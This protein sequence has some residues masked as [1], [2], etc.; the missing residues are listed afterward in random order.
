MNDGLFRFYTRLEMNH[1]RTWS[2]HLLACPTQGSTLLHIDGSTTTQRP[3]GISSSSGG[4]AA[5]F[6][7]SNII[8]TRYLGETNASIPIP[9]PVTG[10]SYTPSLPQRERALSVPLQSRSRRIIYEKDMSETFRSWRPNKSTG[11]AIFITLMYSYQQVS[12]RLAENDVGG[13]IDS[14]VAARLSFW[15]ITTYL[16]RTRRNH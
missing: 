15:S 1:I 5:A 10:E 16:D 4:P 6:R 3:P 12:G 11:L 13:F 7:R 9:T 14:A 8:S 2:S